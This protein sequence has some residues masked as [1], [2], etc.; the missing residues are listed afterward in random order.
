[1]RTFYNVISSSNSRN[2][3]SGY[4]KVSVLTLS[5]D[6]IIEL[7]N[8]ETLRWG[9]HLMQYAEGIG[10]LPVTPYGDGDFTEFVMSRSWRDGEEFEAALAAMKSDGKLFEIFKCGKQD[11]EFVALAEN[12]GLGEAAHKMIGE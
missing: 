11:V 9:E 7:A 1:M 6:E 4:G 10:M 2:S 3:A 5:E 12:F 8:A